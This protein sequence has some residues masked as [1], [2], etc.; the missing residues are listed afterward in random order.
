MVC[1][2]VWLFAKDN[3]YLIDAIFYQNEQFLTVSNP[4]TQVHIAD[5]KKS[6]SNLRMLKL[7]AVQ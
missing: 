7:V 6:F 4:H 2:M 3:F 5:K 1:I